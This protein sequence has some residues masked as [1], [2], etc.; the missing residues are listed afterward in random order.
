MT[1][2]TLVHV[3]SA[4]KL[5]F[6]KECV[7]CCD[8][9]LKW[10]VF[11]MLSWSDSFNKHLFQSKSPPSIKWISQ[12]WSLPGWACA[13]M[14]CDLPTFFFQVQWWPN[15][16]VPWL[17]HLDSVLCS[18]GNAK[19]PKASRHDAMCNLESGTLGE[20]FNEPPTLH[21][22]NCGLEHHDVLLVDHHKGTWSMHLCT[23]AWEIQERELPRSSHK[24]PTGTH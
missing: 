3:P 11:V 21:F 5:G 20:P 19:W 16:L 2:E 6:L 8:V 23:V 1:V 9:L 14:L 17:N 15:Y 18:C 7:C 12:K 22:T 4:S 13:Q 10:Q 24:Q